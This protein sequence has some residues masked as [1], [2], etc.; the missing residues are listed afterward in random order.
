MEANYGIL[1]VIPAIIVIGL[2]LYTKKTVISLLIGTFIGVTI[3][4]GW[5]PLVAVVSFFRDYL[6]P[7]VTSVG[8]MKT[9]IIIFIIQGFVRMLKVTGAGVSIARWTRKYIKSKRSA[10][11]TTCA[12]GFAFIYNRAQLCLGRCHASRDRGVQCCP[13]QA[14]LHY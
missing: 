12:S 14:G 6:Y 4:N 11:V 10:E 3:L 13:R 8:N 5:N 9:I 2:A 7:N 1:S